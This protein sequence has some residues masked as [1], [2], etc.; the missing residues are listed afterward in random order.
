MSSYIF[1][2]FPNLKDFNHALHYEP[3]LLN[4]EW[5]LVNGITSKKSVYVF[6]DHNTLVITEN[7][8]VSKTTWSIKENNSF[9]IENEDGKI[10]VNAFFKDEDILVLQHQKTEDFALFINESKYSEDLNS[11]E[12]VQKFLHDKYAQKATELIYEHEFY[13]I[14]KAKEYGPYKVEVLAEKVKNKSISELCFVRDVNEY[15]YS[16]KL[17]IR[18]LLK[19]F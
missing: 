2:L 5:V 7:E 16:K 19:A 1:K 13:Y 12:D 18:D 3:L 8:S 17:R 11:F 15:D 9:F 10:A 6:E 4:Q 14:K